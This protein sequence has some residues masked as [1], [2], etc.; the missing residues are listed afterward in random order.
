MENVAARSSIWG[1]IDIAAFCRTTGYSREHATRELSQL[2]RKG[3][4]VFETKIRTTGEN[5]AKQ[6]GVM[7]ADPAKLLFDKH[8]LFYGRDGK[9]LHTYTTLGHDGEKLT[10]TIE[11]QPRKR[12]RGRPRNA[13]AREDVVPLREPAAPTPIGDA[14]SAN[15]PSEEPADIHQ[16]CDNAYIGE[17][18]YGIQQPDQYGAGR[19]IAQWRGQELSPS[20]GQ[21]PPGLRRKAFAMLERLEAC[22]WDTCK[23]TFASRTAFNFALAALMDGHAAERLVS[24]YADALHVCHGFAVDRAASTGKITFFNSSST[25]VKAAALLARDGLSR[26]ERVARWYRQ[27]HAEELIPKESDLDPIELAQM[28]AQMLASFPR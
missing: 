5:G 21:G 14:P 6:W 18:S 4:L 16:V 13:D 22:H 25:V 9:P 7:V 15:A 23:V 11:M 10:P 24:C 28:R 3:N 19:D 12:P 2:R 20:G 27:K 17:D 26:Q 1:D 8:S